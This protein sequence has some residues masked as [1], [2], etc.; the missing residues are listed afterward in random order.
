MLS[1][2][3]DSGLSARIRPVAL[4]PFHVALQ[5]RD[6]A[7]ARRFYGD[8][9][10][11]SEGRSAPDWV[12]FNMYGHQFVCH[13]KSAARARRAHRRALQSRRRPWRAGAALWGGARAT[14]VARTGRAAAGTRGRVG[15]RA[16]HALQGPP[17]R[18]VHALHSGSFG[19]RARVQVLR[20]PRAIVRA[21]IRCGAPDA[22]LARQR[23]VVKGGGGFAH[24][25]RQLRARQ[26]A[27][28]PNGRLP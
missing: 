3:A 14:A 11:C 12:D 9:L 1:A 24:R 10:G 17:G 2:A 15:D 19:Q 25:R 22:L 5:V 26:G 20:R 13:L 7:E 16:H 21:L 6:L 27:Q 28:C 18:A 8:T 23:D 4:T